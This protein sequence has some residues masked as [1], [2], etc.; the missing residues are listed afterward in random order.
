MGSGNYGVDPDIVIDL[1]AAEMEKGI[2][3][4]LMKALEILLQK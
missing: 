3:A 1:T 2:D 4:Q